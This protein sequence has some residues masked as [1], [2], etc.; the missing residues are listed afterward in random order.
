MP[1]AFA[2]YVDSSIRRVLKKGVHNWLDNIIIPTRILGEQ[3]ELLCEAFDCL[4]QSKLSV[5]LPKL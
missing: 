1:L 3:S 5:N 2:N 4:R